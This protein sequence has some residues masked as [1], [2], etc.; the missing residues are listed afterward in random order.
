MCPEGK[1][2]ITVLFTWGQLLGLATADSSPLLIIIWG[3]VTI[4]Q[5]ERGAS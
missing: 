1:V 4:F 5:A 3:L 2:Q